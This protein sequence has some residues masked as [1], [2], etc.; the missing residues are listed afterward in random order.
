MRS[1][2]AYIVMLIIIKSLLVNSRSCISIPKKQDESYGDFSSASPGECIFCS[3]WKKSVINSYTIFYSLIRR[4][5]SFGT[6]LMGKFC[7]QTP[8]DEFTA[9]HSPVIFAVKRANVTLM[10]A[11]QGLL[12]SQYL[13]ALNYIFLK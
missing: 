5:F 4:S 13:S 8:A 2:L 9:I 3:D 12:F 11:S 10:E 7:N 1:D 6:G